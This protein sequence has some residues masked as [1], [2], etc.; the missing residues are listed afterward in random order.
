MGGSNAKICHRVPS[1]WTIR[2][3]RTTERT[4]R[5]IGKLPNGQSSAKPEH[6]KNRERGDLSP[7]S[8]A[9]M[10]YRVPAAYISAY[11]IAQVWINSLKSP[12]TTSATGS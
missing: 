5:E 4:G 3:S 10:S 1:S 9:M 11:S 6:S 8:E 7:R 12:I 2:A